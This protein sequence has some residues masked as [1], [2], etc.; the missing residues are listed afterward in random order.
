MTGRDPREPGTP[1]PS[2][3][4]ISEFFLSVVNAPVVRLMV[5]LES[6]GQ[7][8]TNNEPAPAPKAIG[9]TRVMANFMAGQPELAIERNAGYRAVRGEKPPLWQAQIPVNGFYRR[10]PQELMTDIPPSAPLR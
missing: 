6:A 10:A 5:A 1:Q 9:C 7:C 2:V 4:P 8:D 3:R